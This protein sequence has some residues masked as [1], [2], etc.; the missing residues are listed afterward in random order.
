MARNSSWYRRC[1][2][3]PMCCSAPTKVTMCRAST[4][5]ARDGIDLGGQTCT[6]RQLRDWRKPVLSQNRLAP[7]VAR[8]GGFW[9]LEMH[10]RAQ[11]R[12]SKVEAYTGQDYVNRDQYTQQRGGATCNAERCLC[13][14]LL[15]EEQK[16]LT[17]F[18]SFAGNASKVWSAEHDFVKATDGS[19]TAWVPTGKR[20][21]PKHNNLA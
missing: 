10:N 7:A 11:N 14:V 8:E 20:M 18:I 15:L 16:Q 21:N 2:E 19:D 4:E 9:N 1:H 17:R 6:T 13:K 12:S 5:S 3:L